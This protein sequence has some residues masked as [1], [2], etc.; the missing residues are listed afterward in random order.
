MLIAYKGPMY[1]KL[2]PSANKQVLRFLALTGLVFLVSLSAQ[3]QHRTDQGLT[4]G[5]GGGGEFPGDGFGISINGGYDIPSGSLGNTYK[6]APTFGFSLVDNFDSFTLSLNVATVTYKPKVDTT[7]YYA[8]NQTIGSLAWSNDK[9][10]EY[11]LG[12]AYNIDVDDG[13]K[14]YIG[15][16]L[17]IYSDQI[18]YHTQDD[19]ENTVVNKTLNEIYYAPKLGFTFAASDNFSVSPGLRYNF[20]KPLGS[21]TNDTYVSTS[22]KSITLGIALTYIF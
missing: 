7:Y 16:N 13:V 11:Y 8:A 18:G 3:A 1:R 15:L 4:Y 6:A 21:T 22:N 19:Y 17:G 14:F 9:I 20:F 10:M 2:Y 5:G 12:G